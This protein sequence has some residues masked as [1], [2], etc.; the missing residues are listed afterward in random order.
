MKDDLKTNFD[1][2]FD[3]ALTAVDTGGTSEDDGTIIDMSKYISA[4][5]QL[6]VASMVATSTLV[7][8]LQHSPDGTTWTDEDGSTG[9]DISTGTLLADTAAGKVHTL[10]IVKPQ[11]QYYQAHCVVGTEAVVA[12]VVQVLGPKRSI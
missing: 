6:V 9:N 8:K 7:I 5:V 3:Q 4:L 12:S 1:V 10:N 2:V 11:A